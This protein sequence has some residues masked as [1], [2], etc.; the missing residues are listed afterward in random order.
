M[1]PFAAD[2]SFCTPGKTDAMRSLSAQLT[3]APALS[4]IALL[5]R[6]TPSKSRPRLSISRSP[7]AMTDRNTCSASRSASGARHV[8]AVG[9][10]F[11]GGW[12]AVA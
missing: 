7:S 11:A 6:A 9:W 1:K 12:L 8:L 2:P 10:T 3:I 5:A 4:R